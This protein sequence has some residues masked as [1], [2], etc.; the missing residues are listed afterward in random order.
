[1]SE[2]EN[3]SYDMKS[4][5]RRFL[6]PITR[7]ILIINL[8]AVAIPI[9]GL[10]YL[11]PYREG[12]IEAELE[13]LQIESAIIAGAVGEGAIESVAPGYQVLNLSM[14]RH[15]IRRLSPSTRV[16][17][18]LFV[19]RG[20]LV[21][22][23]QLLFGSG[24]VVRVRELPP[25]DS[26]NWVFSRL[27]DVIDWFTKW[28]PQ[29]QLYESYNQPSDREASVYDE[30]KR[31]LNGEP[32]GRVRGDS[33]GNLVLSY[34]QPVQRYRQVLA[35][36]VLSKDDTE[37]ERA[38]RQVRL[39]ILQIFAGALVITVLLSFYLAGTIARPIRLLAAAAER[40]RHGLGRESQQ[41]PDLTQR[42][43]EI[44]ELSGSLRE[45]TDALHARMDSI[46]TFAADVSHELKNPLTSL[47]SAV[48]TAAR[49]RDSV[50]QRRL[51]SIIIEDVQRLDRLISD[52]SNASRLDSE[53]S[54]AEFEVVDV[55]TILI[56][57]PI[58][59]TADGS[60]QPR[61][62]VDVELEKN[63]SIKVI[64]ERLN[65]VFSNLI[66]NAISFSPSDS[67]ILL[68]ATRK[69]NFAEI[70][71]EDEG[72]GIP[73]GKL[74][75]I[76]SR[77]YTERPSNEKFGIHS[78]LGLSISKQIIEAQ[79]GT[80]RAENWSDTESGASGARF[81]VCLPLA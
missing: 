41:I 15:M 18:R 76:F 26:S 7:K 47:R 16:R 56:E 34:S 19:A 55:S 23:S 62:K 69:E 12:L 29:H 48:E 31:A 79:G 11:G 42:A 20:G 21:A 65:Q 33:I 68:K 6:S 59:S 74:N 58:L 32:N 39:T 13:A 2:H 57:L 73:E 35:S 63:L 72:P 10:L 37:I 46:E 77:F 54:R 43:D 70:V 64:A 51:M 50:Q 67:T 3:I 9:G 38:L 45:M 30:A 27:L 61:I 40:V 44:G 52:I 14:A 8:L 17:T 4:R 53:L 36:I 75:E 25:H 24:R 81:I 49:V 5:R 78:G 60:V 28:L 1:M 71:V 66:D 80:I 22:D